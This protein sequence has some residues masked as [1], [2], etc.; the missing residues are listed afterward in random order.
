MYALD[1]NAVIHF[2][3]A[4][5]R[6]GE[7]LLAMPPDEIG[8]PAIVVF[9]L[10]RGARKSAGGEGRIERL[11]R[12]I[13]TVHVLPFDHHAARR[14]A[15]LALHLESIGQPIGPLDTLIAATAL[16][17]GA[18]LVTHNTSEFSRVPELKVVDWF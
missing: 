5:G 8:L 2:F 10:E 11:Q 4:K 9:E 16:A 6:V 12:F 15:D 18:T 7:R 1:T 3:K 13:A 17:Q 14:A